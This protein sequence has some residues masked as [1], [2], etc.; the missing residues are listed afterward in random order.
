MNSERR[1]VRHKLR[2]VG[3]WLSEQ[4]ARERVEALTPLIWIIIVSVFCMCVFID[5]TVISLS[6][7]LPLTAILIPVAGFLLYRLNKHSEQV[8]RYHQ[9]KEGELSVA[10]ILEPLKAQGGWILNDIQA[11]GFN[12]DLVYVSRKGVFAIEVKNPTI[13]NDKEIVRFDGRD[14][15]IG[16]KKLF[17]NP[18]NQVIDAARWLHEELAPKVNMGSFFV[19]PVLLFPTSWEVE[20]MSSETKKHIWILNAHA[21]L[22]FIAN[23]KE[24]LDEKAVT[25]F[26]E[27]LKGYSRSV[28]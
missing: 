21:F 20:K 22:T 28:S 23:E 9:G 5:A 24:H 3:E 11:R 4:I 6:K 13:Q 2:Q 10:E 25:F 7:L 1:Y 16:E 19:K 8:E 15:Y 17:K 27:K 26:V 18:V 12:I 14:T